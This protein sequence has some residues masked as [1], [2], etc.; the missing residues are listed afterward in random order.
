MPEQCA[1]I[2]D[3]P[4]IPVH[5]ALDVAHGAYEQA[6]A[7]QGLLPDAI[8]VIRAMAE[9]NIEELNEEE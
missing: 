9:L 8:K 5:A 4:P 7:Q 1:H 6:M 3:P 2:N